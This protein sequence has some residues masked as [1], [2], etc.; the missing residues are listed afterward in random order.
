MAQRRVIACCIL[1]KQQCGLN[2]KKHNHLA[3]LWLKHH[4]CYV[5]HNMFIGSTQYQ[6]GA[7]LIL[8]KNSRGAKKVRL[9]LD[10][11]EKL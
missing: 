2:N 7:R 4:D 10:K 8:S 3:L 5:K 11:R 1:L 6:M 9:L